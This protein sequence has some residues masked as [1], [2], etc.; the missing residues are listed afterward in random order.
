MLK[1]A[2]ETFTCAWESVSP[3]AVLTLELSARENRSITRILMI[4]SSTDYAM[5]SKLHKERSIISYSFWA[6]LSHIH[7]WHGL[8]T[9]FLHHLSRLS[10]SSTNVS[11]SR[12]VSS[13]SLMVQ[14]IFWTIWTTI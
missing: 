6:F 1:S 7:G 10:D 11:V 8:K 3:S 12:E 14:S 2:L 5:S 4:S 9:S 13:I